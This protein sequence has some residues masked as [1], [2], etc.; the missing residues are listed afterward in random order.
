[1]WPGPIPHEE[2]D[3]IGVVVATTDAATFIEMIQRRVRRA[4]ETAGVTQQGGSHSAAHVLFPPVHE[5]CAGGG[6]PDTGGA[7]RSLDDPAVYAPESGGA[8]E[9][10]WPARSQDPGSGGGEIG[11]TTNR[12]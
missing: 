12:K 9:R 10:D 7:C 3:V 2:S 6:D 1:M 8:A 4:A 11:E 5:R